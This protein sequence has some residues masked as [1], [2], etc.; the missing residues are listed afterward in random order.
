VIS[1]LKK[2]TI[3]GIIWAGFGSI[4]SQAIHYIVLLILAWLL[5]PEDFG[6]LGIAMMFILFTQAITE[7]GFGQP[8]IQHPEIK[9]LD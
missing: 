8:I 3:L 1:P 7:L 6:L 4:G 5:E 9:N 2:K